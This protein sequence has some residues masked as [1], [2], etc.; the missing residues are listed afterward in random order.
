L[1]YIIT[2]AAFIG[3]AL[4][5]L[6][7]KAISNSDLISSDSFRIL[8]G[9]NIFFICSLIILIAVQIFRLLQSVKK[10]I[11]GSR[12][13]LRLV[14][15]FALMGIVPVLIVYL[16]SV[17]FLT[18]SIES[19][20]DV[21]VES[22]LEGGLTLGQK[23]I[24]ILMSD[25]E[26]KGKSIA[27]SI[28]NADTDERYNILTDLRVKFGIQDAVIF[29]QDSKIIE[30]SSDKNNLIPSIPN[31]EDLER[32]G[33]DFFG[34][35][36][37][38]KGEEIYLKVFIPIISK[39]LMSKRL[40]LQLTQP[41]PPSIANL[42]LSVESVYDEYQQLTYSR[43]SLKIIYILT[44]TLV[45]LL[46]LLSSVAASFVISR[47]FSSPL[48]MVANATREISKG[49]YKKI[50][51]EQ[52]KD[53]IGVLIRAF[54][55]MTSQL[56]EA[57]R[58]SEKDRERLEVARTFLETILAHLTT[59][60]IVIDDKKIIKLNNVSAS[61][62]L[63]NKE[64]KMNDTAMNKIILNNSL[65]EPLYEFVE[66]YID[67]N[68]KN[69]KEVSQEFRLK[70]DKEE[71]TI[72]L[73]ITPLSD[74]RSTK[75]VLVIDDISE[76]TQAQRH[77]AWGEIARRLA[78]E[79][80]NPLTPIQLSA[81]R[82]QHKFS[83]KLNKEDSI[84]LERSTNTIVNQVN[85]LKIM[86]NE[87]AEY[88]RPTKIK[89]DTVRIDSLVDEVIELYEINKMISIKKEKNI[90]IIYADQNKLRQV[91]INLI[92]NSQDAL[93]EIKKPKIKIFI[94]KKVNEVELI[95]EDNGI[96]IPDEIIG[97][98]FEPYITS[99]KT[100]TGLGLAIVHKIIEEHD[101]KIKIERISNS[102]TRVIIT[103]N[104]G[105]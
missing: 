83:N 97:R 47:R 52:G 46:A 18:K 80:K 10:E 92:E 101:G 94:K 104:S 21:K 96:G 3:I 90:P 72:M 78:H 74:K 26:L 51:S 84:I 103:F 63:Q 88:A 12:L 71:R 76:V 9:L 25:I 19:W 95:V 93:K 53:E 31:I 54:N 49:N 20:F 105:K 86:V 17:N 66:T 65:F 50:I 60:V 43:N 67:G 42:A 64:N 68:K 99:K 102:G 73:Q 55:S 5:I 77:S 79:I 87:F 13:T 23:T 16:V 7:A 8:L 14:L 41:I 33:E 82:I 81:E 4:L 24:D 35:I 85:A 56:E 75:Y 36:E 57:T 45:L 59:G 2:T 98:I 91:I 69:K 34:R 30:V 48:A 32:G 37:E 1:K 62:M 6:L 100:G 89:K 22:A 38:I 61:K 70:K 28:G 58:N 15:S 39:N 40:I 27:Y 11:T 44:L 29:D